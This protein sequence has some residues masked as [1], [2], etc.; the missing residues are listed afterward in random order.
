MHLIVLST[1][2]PVR[3]AL[4]SLAA[5]EGFDAVAVD[6][7]RACIA[8][9]QQHGAQ[10]LVLL[11]AMHDDTL[12]GAFLPVADASSIRVALLS[13]PTTDHL[14]PHPAVRYTLATPFPSTALR[15]FLRSLTRPSTS[16]AVSGTRA[17]PVI[18]TDGSI[19]ARRR[20]ASRDD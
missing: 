4:T 20:R 2:T 9:L 6:S 5:Q 13:G 11:D 12:A 18:S 1:F 7:I 16:R 19:P 14:I 8:A 17:R 10:T 15:T 3:S